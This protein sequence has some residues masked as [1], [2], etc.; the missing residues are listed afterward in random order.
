MLAVAHVLGGERDRR[1]H[2]DHREHLHQ[3]ILDH[4]AQRAGP[5]V[6]ARAALDADGLGCGD[7]H[8]IDVPAIPPRLEHAVR[9]AEY[10]QV[11]DGL[12]PQVVIDAED[13]RFVQ[14]RVQEPVQLTRAVEIGPERLLDDDP[15]PAAGR[16]GR[17]QAGGAQLFDDGRIGHRRDREV[18]QHAVRAAHL[19]ELVRDL[20]VEAG[21]VHFTL[22]VA[23]I[24]RQRRRDLVGLR[25]AGELLEAVVK[26]LAELVVGHRGSGNAK[27]VEPGRQPL[28]P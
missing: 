1:L 5:L 23:E 6:V 2:R 11:L 9:E 19:G 28:A 17:R 21:I 18:E 4:V 26:L 24:A 10:E 14:V 22:D 7:L 27:D 15:A 16:R 12:F 13:L 8:V 3:V 20:L 25:H